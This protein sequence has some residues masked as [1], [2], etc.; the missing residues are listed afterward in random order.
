MSYKQVGVNT[1]LPYCPSGHN[2]SVNVCNISGDSKDLVF[3]LKL[4]SW[5]DGSKRIIDLYDSFVQLT[6]GESDAYGTDDPWL[7][8]ES[9]KFMIYFDGSNDFLL[10]Q[11]GAGY[12]NPRLH[13]SFT[14]TTWIYPKSISA[15]QGLFSKRDT[16]APV[17]EN[18]KFYLGITTGGNL[19]TT[20]TQYDEIPATYTS[21]TLDSTQGNLAIDTWQSITT[22]Y[23]FS[24]P[25]TYMTIY[26]DGVLL[27]QQQVQ[28]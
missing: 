21:V 15:D 18:T 16:N 2:T 19:S 26:L 25:W 13:H 8:R 17:G 12:A 9:E 1:C 5:N 11:A 22:T 23:R 7:D 3:H 4:Q 6:R 27:E 14:V 28:N 24:Y 10:F 20:F